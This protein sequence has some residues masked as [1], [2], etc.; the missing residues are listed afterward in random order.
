MNANGTMTASE[1][2]Q[3]SIDEDRTVTEYPETQEEYDSLLDDLLSSSNGDV[4]TAEQVGAGHSGSE[5]RGWTEIWSEDGWRV[6]LVH[7]PA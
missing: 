4:D 2:I 3:L 6:D 5:A 1:L 7:P